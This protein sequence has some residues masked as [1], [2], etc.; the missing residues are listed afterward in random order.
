MVSKLQVM[1]HLV[2]QMAANVSSDSQ[3]LLDEKKKLDQVN[4]IESKASATTNKVKTKMNKAAAQ[5]ANASAALSVAMSNAVPVRQ[6]Y[7]EAKVVDAAERKMKILKLQAELSNKKIEL[8]LEQEKLKGEIAAEKTATDAAN[9][10]DAA[11]DAIK[12]AEEI[13]FENKEK[14]MLAHSSSNKELNIAPWEN[15]NNDNH[16][17]ASEKIREIVSHL[18]WSEGHSASAKAASL[19]IV[20]AVHAYQSMADTVKTQ[21]ADVSTARN[22]NGN[23][24]QIK[25]LQDTN[26]LDAKIAGI[27]ESQDKAREEEAGKQAGAFRFRGDTAGEIATTSIQAR[28]VASISNG[29]ASKISAST[30]NP[31]QSG[32]APELEAVP[33]TCFDG[34]QDGH[35]QGVDCGGDCHRQCGMMTVR[36]Q[37]KD[38]SG[39]GYHKISIV[40]R[41]SDDHQK[42]QETVLPT[43]VKKL[44]TS[45]VARAQENGRERAATALRTT[46]LPGEDGSDRVVQGEWTEVGEA[47]KSH[48]LLLELNERRRLRAIQKSENTAK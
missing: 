44:P 10:E 41:T 1:E 29:V 9:A 27:K 31:T 6:T 26:H 8:H 25:Q 39:G 21:D 20:K 5:Y 3:T 12:Q 30:L 40:P 11:S 42:N 16:N 32:G 46:F 37:Q 14:E 24:Q 13:G 22:N 28:G 17:Q 2:E 34:L 48:P 18:L 23:E 43:L 15:E 36:T 19:S 4:S 38:N 33:E 7:E 47:Q 35:E 45:V